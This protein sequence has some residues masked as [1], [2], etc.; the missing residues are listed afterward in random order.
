MPLL[1][2]LYIMIYN[3]QIY[4]SI[5]YP[6]HELDYCNTHYF[7]LLTEDQITFNFKPVKIMGPDTPLHNSQFQLKL[8][9]MCPYLHMYHRFKVI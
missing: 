5:I 6:L 7:G 3:F 8:G 9:N 1:P 4:P 2:Q